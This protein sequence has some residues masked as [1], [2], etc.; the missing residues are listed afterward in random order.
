MWTI[1]FY[2][3]FFPFHSVRVDKIFFL[4]EIV[5]E[6]KEHGCQA[7]NAWSTTALLFCTNNERPC[8]KNETMKKQDRECKLCAVCIPLVCFFLFEMSTN[9]IEQKHSLC[10]C[11]FCLFIRCVYVNVCVWS[12]CMHMRQM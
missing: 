8:K 9:T 11:V 6:E 10:A 12:V 2:F 5:E 4:Y 7:K 3:G 1:F